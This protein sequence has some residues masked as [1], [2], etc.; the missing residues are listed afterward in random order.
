MPG[1][2]RMTFRSVLRASLGVISLIAGI[3]ALDVIAVAAYARPVGAQ[4][5]SSVLVGWI[6][7]SAGVGI[8][9]ADLT[10]EGRG[11]TART[12]SSGRFALRGLDPGPV[13]VRVR[14]MG[15]D[16]QGFE[17]ALRA[18]SVDS[19][20]VTLQARAQPLDAVETEAAARRLKRGLEG[21]EHR[22]AQGAGIFITRD[23]IERHDTDML[24]ETVR[25]VPGI[26]FVHA[27]AGR[28]GIRFNLGNGRSYDCQPLYWVDGR[29]VLNAE[30]DDF[31]ASDVEAIE[32]YQGPATTPVQ[33]ASGRMNATCGTVVIWTRIPPGD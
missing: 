32:M 23:D 6:R 26:H 7:D 27:G 3:A 19:V 28:Q 30:L 25:E 12:D 15:Y 18:S 1:V 24:S 22:R 33:F 2:S 29:K 13:T 10:V 31:P 8:Q 16:P 17:Y 14:R 9:L 21:F 11:L 5:G 4:R 20:S